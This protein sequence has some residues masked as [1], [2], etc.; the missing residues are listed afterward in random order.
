MART[1]VKGTQ[2]LDGSIG[3]SDLNTTISGNA[4]ITKIIGSN[5]L[6]ITSSSGID[7]G[8]GD[9]TLATDLNFLNGKYP[10]L[11]VA[12]TQNYVFAGPSSGN[13]NPAFRA[14]VAGDIPSIAISGVTGLQAVLDSKISGSGTSGYLA[15]YTGSLSHGNSIMYDSGSG[16]GIGTSAP[17]APL[18][19]QSNLVNRKIVLYEQVNN[20]HQYIGFGVNSGTVRYQSNGSGTAHVFYAASGGSTSNELF[21]ITGTGNIGIGNA[22]PA[23]KLDV[24]G[25]GH[26]SGDVTFGA[27]G[28]LATAPTTGNHL[29]N[30]TYVDTKISG[31]GT[32]GYLAKYT[33]SLTHGNSVIFE[34]SGN[35]G[36]GTT[37]PYVRTQISS[38][39]T[40]VNGMTAG[41]PAG[42]G[43]TVSNL[44]NAYGLNM[45]VYSNG[46]AWIQAARLDGTA[47]T[48]NL[49]L[50]AAGGFVGINTTSPSTVFNVEA[51]I[52]GN[53][54]ANIRNNDNGFSSNGLRVEVAN[55]NSNNTVQRWYVAS[56]EIMR[57]RADGN[58]GI[59]TTSPSYKLDVN[60][61]GRFTGAVTFDAIPSTPIAA[62][63]AN[64]LVNYATMQSYISG[65]K[66]DS[67]KVKTVALSNITLSGHQT[68]SGYT[69][70][71]S[72]RVLVMGQ[73]T[74]SQNG[75]YISNSSTWTRDANFDTEAEI[76]GFIHS[77]ESGTYAGYK[78]INTNSGTIM[79]GTTDITYVEFSSL[80]ETDPVFTASVAYGISSTNISNWNDAYTNRISTKNT[81][82]LAEGSNLYFTTARV[83]STVLTGFTA[84]SNTAITAS[85][86]VLVAF[87]SVQGQINSRI[88][89]GGNTSGA[90]IT[91][92]TND[93]YDFNLERSNAVQMAIKSGVIEANYDF[94]VKGKLKL[95]GSTGVDH[96]FVKYN[97]TAT[98]WATLDTGELSDKNN[99]VML[100]T[101]NG[102]RGFQLFADTTKT[103][104][105]SFLYTN[106]D[107]GVSLGLHGYA[108]DSSDA[109]KEFGIQLDTNGLLYHKKMDG[110]RSQIATIDMVSGGGGTWSG[111]NVNGDIYMI[112][113]KVIEWDHQ[114]NGAFIGLFEFGQ[115]PLTYEKTL[116]INSNDSMNISASDYV[117]VIGNKIFLASGGNSAV[118]LD[119]SGANSFAAG[120]YCRFQVSVS[121]GVRKLSIVSD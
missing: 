112:L 118:E 111:G 53:F 32:S 57:V 99:I 90:A 56:A 92:G 64:H 24:S 76:K 82:D 21:R 49:A 73:S 117:K 68:I 69:T 23:Y 80:V 74:A 45:G 6:A 15:K 5:G 108:L 58:V 33:G 105:E 78:Y 97:G 104:A 88:T 4:V 96:Q 79:V 36:V 7:S 40:G 29:A 46:M 43:F 55:N 100:D 17:N 65:I 72:D 120:Q 18:Q 30:K 113:G 61:T 93:N 84:G 106:P 91:I 87:Q 101:V 95:N 109:V 27:N 42:V 19:F 83:L 47:T 22:S 75:L 121:S 48:Y 9:V 16:I 20:D 37:S 52:A 10:S 1:N 25:T 94:D 114:N 70:S 44:N 89:I 71:G 67:V 50:Q 115:A 77:V 41:S 110:T 119:L 59:N 35:I 81:G 12:R 31:N 26:F 66:Y 60:G 107:A 54:A 62:T 28:I 38:T 63:T 98:V 102:E 8:T 116:V 85:D 51:S 103:Y 2:I 14:L 34:S 13:G 86:T 39:T 3:R 11:E